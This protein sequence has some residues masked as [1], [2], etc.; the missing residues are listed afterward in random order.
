MLS[1]LWFKTGL[2]ISTPEL[3]IFC[4]YAFIAPLPYCFLC[5]NLNPLSIALVETR[6]FC[7]FFGHLFSKSNKFATLECRIGEFVT[8][9]A[10][11]PYVAGQV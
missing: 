10:L 1:A 3:F 5:V 11:T 4:G 6:L 2:G 7:D 8:N 9:K